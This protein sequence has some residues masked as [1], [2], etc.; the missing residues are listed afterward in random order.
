MT[1]TERSYTLSVPTSQLQVIVAALGKLPL[2]IVSTTYDS[3]RMQV[4]AQDAQA[5]AQASGHGVGANGADKEVVPPVPP[6]PTRGDVE[7][8]KKAAA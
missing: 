8:E 3:V 1:A 4:A 2:E 5:M 7:Q 6:M